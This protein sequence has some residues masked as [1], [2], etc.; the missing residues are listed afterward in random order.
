M[1]SLSNKVDNLAFKEDSI[2]KLEDIED[3]KQYSRRNNLILHGIPVAPKED[4]YERVMT[5]AK[6]LQVE[7]YPNDFDIIHR[8]GSKNNNL[9]PPI[10]IRFVNRWKKEELQEAIQ[11]KRELKAMGWSQ[12]KYLY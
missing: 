11:K 9:P 6:A 12:H 1:T 2:T 5:V 10:I 4:L 8:L 3:S 7:T